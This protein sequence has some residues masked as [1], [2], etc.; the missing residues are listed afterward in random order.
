MKEFVLTQPYNSLEEMLNSAEV[1]IYKEELRQGNIEKYAIVSRIGNRYDLEGDKLI[2]FAPNPFYKKS[3]G[4]VTAEITHEDVITAVEENIMEEKEMKYPEIETLIDEVVAKQ[5]EGVK[6]AHEEEI[7]KL[8]EE[9]TQ[10]L[11]KAKAEA[12]AELIA[13]L[14]D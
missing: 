8:K 7:A 5:V 6:L 4:F 12:K 10:E 2:E 14:N 9:H 13:K 1:A 11:V 3:V